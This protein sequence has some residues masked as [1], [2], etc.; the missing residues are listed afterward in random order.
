VSTAAV[1]QAVDAAFREEWGRVVAQLIRR[2]GD[3]D[4]AEEC[5]QEAFA[6]A[7]AGRRHPAAP[8]RVADHCGRPPGD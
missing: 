3:W 5:T 6:E 2:T 8:G 4:L 7:L 1:Q